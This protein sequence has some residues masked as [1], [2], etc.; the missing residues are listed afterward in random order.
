MK[1]KRLVIFGDSLQDHGNLTKLLP[2]SP[3][4]CHDGYFS[5]GPVA[6]YYLKDGLSQYYND[7]INIQNFAVAG[8]LAATLNPNPLLMDKSLAV[9][10]QV[11]QFEHQFG[12]FKDDDLIVITGGGNNFFFSIVPDY[13]YLH[14]GNIYRI[15]NDLERIVDRVCRLGAKE[16]LLSNIP[17]VTAVPV[18]NYVPEGKKIKPLA[19]RHIIYKIRSIV[20]RYYLNRL[21]KENAKLDKKIDQLKVKYRDS[22]IHLFDGFRFMRRV[23]NKPFE[24]GFENATNPS[25]L[26]VGGFDL[27]GNIQSDADILVQENPDTHLFWDLVHPTTKAHQVVADEWL[28]YF[29]Q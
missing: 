15:A 29:I 14:L 22:Q 28:K 23:M 18:F 26:S 20:K 5:N 16:I 13:P 4:A 3:K 12:R 24:F 7:D 19:K 25:I 21:T 27:K 11:D 9:A 6:V 1:I 8:A 17:D 10:D 2:L